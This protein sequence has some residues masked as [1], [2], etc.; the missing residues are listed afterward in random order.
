MSATISI[1]PPGLPPFQRADLVTALM[2]GSIG[3]LLILIGPQNQWFDF[4]L[5]PDLLALPIL[6][7]CGF[8]GTLYAPRTAISSTAFIVGLGVDTL[9]GGHD[10]ALWL[11]FQLVF[12]LVGHAPGH[13]SRW[14]YN[15]A[16]VVTLLSGVAAFAAGLDISTAFQLTLL[17]G[18]VV[19]VPALWASNVREHQNAAR[20]EHD[21]AEA[22]RARADAQA[23]SLILA[24]Q[25]AA[26][27]AK[28]AE[29][30]TRGA[31][32]E[33]LHDL[34]AGHIS[35]IA[36]Q[37]QAALVGGDDDMRTKVLTTIHDSANRALGELRRM[38][39]LLS[40]DPVATDPSSATISETLAFARSLGID[41][42]GDEAVDFLDSELESALRPVFAEL[43]AHVMKHASRRSL[44][45]SNPSPGTIVAANP[46]EP[47]DHR[48]SAETHGVRNI[49]ERLDRLG[50]S[51]DFAEHDGRFVVTIICPCPDAEDRPTEEETQ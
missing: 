47:N 43:V 27:S 7:I 13:I 22:E 26:V 15:L 19:F 49:R 37:S 18:L 9:A 24:A 21:R 45:L 20:A 10:F 29:Q 14:T 48:R 12:A 16:L 5:I 40:A 44:A 8:L 38:I 3:V 50:G 51:A 32:A 33:D 2:L 1:K 34:V 23:E 28:I 4:T 35:A 30:K 25:N 11:V 41:V 42:S 17:T 6:V 36:L 31:A 46:A 39:D